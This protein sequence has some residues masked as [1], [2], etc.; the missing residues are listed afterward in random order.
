MATTTETE[1]QPVE[2]TACRACGSFDF[3]QRSN[4]IVDEEGYLDKSGC[5][6]ATSTETDER[7]AIFNLECMD[8]GAAVEEG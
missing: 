3:K 8:C 7:N 1:S 6:V 2:K 5:F 4:S